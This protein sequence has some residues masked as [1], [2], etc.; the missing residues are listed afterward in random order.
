MTKMTYQV[1]MVCCQPMYHVFYTY[2]ILTPILGR[3]SAKRRRVS[4]LSV[5]EMLEQKMQ[6]K[7]ELKERELDIRKMELELQK[8]MDREEEEGKRLE[9]ER[10]KH[11]ELEFSERRALL[12]LIQKLV[13][14]N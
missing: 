8:K 1:C 13:A 6:R 11:M 4:K 7:S 2:I 10:Q 9:E 3:A 5:L 12:E 14:K